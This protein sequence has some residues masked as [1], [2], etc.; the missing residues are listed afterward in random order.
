MSP[1][2]DPSAI[3][4]FALRSGHG[5]GSVAGSTAGGLEDSGVRAV[6]AH[7]DHC[8][9]CSEV[10]AQLIQL[11]GSGER[12]RALALTS[13]HERLALARTVAAAARPRIPV[14]ASTIGRYRILS[15]LG[16]GAMG[17]VYAA[18]DQSSIAPSR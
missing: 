16:E 7:V 15:V 4:A 17:A 3:D 2:P 12:E 11:Y 1:C 9:S 6:A 8:A 14:H 13:S 10:L 18:H 5:L